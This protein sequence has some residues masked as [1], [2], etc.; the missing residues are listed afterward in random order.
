M[1]Q[2]SFENQ[3]MAKD[4]DHPVAINKTSWL[5][6]FFFGKDYIHV[7]V[8]L[9]LCQATGHAVDYSTWSAR[10]LSEEVRYPYFTWGCF[11]FLSTLCRNT[12][13]KMG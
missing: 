9:Y 12:L 7:G 1:T 5:C 2:A 10:T 6:K 13:N 3:A 4:S 8:R 11:V